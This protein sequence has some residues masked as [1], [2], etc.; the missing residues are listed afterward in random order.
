MANIT[1]NP[2][3]GVGSG[4]QVAETR[5]DLLMLTKL[6]GMPLGPTPTAVDRALG[7]LISREAKRSGFTG[8]L[9]QQLLVE[10][11]PQ[12]HPQCPQRYILLVGLG[13]PQKFCGKVA[14]QVFRLVIDKALELGVEHVTI[15]FAPNRMTVSSLN[16]KGTAHILRE[17]VD[18]KLS[19][20]KGRQSLKE[21]Q[22]LCTP[23]ARKHIQDGLDI[24][25]R[26]KRVCCI[27]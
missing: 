1:V 7:G 11:D 18:E 12:S 16:L 5:T 20:R 15:P 13:S 24:P 22:L 2:I 8:E 9:G 26:H 17:V 19:G 25:A 23:Q 14:C 3:M 21:I 4:P 6:E 10:I 27:D